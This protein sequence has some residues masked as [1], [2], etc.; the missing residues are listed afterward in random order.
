MEKC[1]VLEEA[2][3]V[4]LAVDRIGEVSILLKI[5]EGNLSRFYE[6][7]FAEN[8]PG[9]ELV[10]KFEKVARFS[11]NRMPDAGHTW[12]LLATSPTFGEEIPQEGPKTVVGFDFLDASEW[13]ASLGSVKENFEHFRISTVDATFEVLFAQGETVGR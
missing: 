6:G 1:F 9:E 4:R 10:I 3:L 7:K 13:L 11:M 8:F 2:S 12:T 5:W